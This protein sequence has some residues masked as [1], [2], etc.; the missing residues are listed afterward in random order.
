MLFSLHKKKIIIPQF[1]NLMSFLHL[2]VAR[3]MNIREYYRQIKPIS[4]YFEGPQTACNY[5][6]TLYKSFSDLKNSSCA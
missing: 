1:G 5:N 2:E 4:A 3:L 6:C